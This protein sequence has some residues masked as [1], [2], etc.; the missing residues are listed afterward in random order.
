M[1]GQMKRETPDEKWNRLQ[2]QV[3]EG[4]AKAY[5]N[6]ERNGCVNGH[7]IRELARRAAAFG[8]GIEEEP[9]WKHVTHCSPCY[10]QYLQEFNNRRR[11]KPPSSAE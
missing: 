11:R 1:F 2:R 10:A 8:D 4:I 3:E 6:P 7:A 5:A 9:D